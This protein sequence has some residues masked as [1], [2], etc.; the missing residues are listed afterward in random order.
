MK[1]QPMIWP[2][3]RLIFRLFKGILSLSLGV[4]SGVLYRDFSR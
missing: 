1:N 3:N 4:V 2:A